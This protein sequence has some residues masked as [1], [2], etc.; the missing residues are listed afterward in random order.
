M[1]TIRFEELNT[2]DFLAAGFDKVIL[3][4]GSCESHD[5]HLPFGTDGFV[6]HD[7]ALAVAERVPGTM[8]LPPT[9]Y[10]MSG[11]YRHKPMCVTLSHATTIALYRDI[12]QSVID[13][14]FKKILVINGHDGNI[15]CIHVAAQET[16]MANPEVGL[17][18]LDAWWTVALTLLPKE[19]WERYA[20]Y[21][22]GG[23]GE[24]SI[25]L[26]MIPHLTRP[27]R[28]KGMVDT[29]DPLI[30]EI[31]NYQ[32]LTDHG[33]TGDGR[34]ATLEKGLAMKK[35]LVDHTVAFLDRKEREGWVIPKRPV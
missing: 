19:M 16:K 31:W 27:E 30:K 14:G 33:A 17:A 7:L 26:A 5:D 9:F 23:E 25:A 1:P 15:P 32:E 21:G 3:P 11:H 35:V 34:A 2:A 12:L 13:W 29:K 24:T 4:I 20:G 6:A 18:L 22:H 28:A 10:G 8:V